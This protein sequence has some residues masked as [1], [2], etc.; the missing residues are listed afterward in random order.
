M[1]IAPALLADVNRVL[2]KRDARPRAALPEGRG[3][4]R[5][6]SQAGTT[7]TLVYDEIGYW[8]V[9]ARDVIAALADVSTPSITVRINSPGGDVFDGIA[10]YNALRGHPAAVNVVVD[11]L[12]ASAASFIAMAADRITMNAA[13]QLMI[14]D[15][16]GFAYGNAADMEHMRALL[17][18]VSD[19]IASIY[20]ERAGNDVADWRALM[21]DESWFNGAEAVAAGL[22]DE[23]ADPDEDDEDTDPEEETGG[24]PGPAARWDLSCFTFAGR[25]H[26][27]APPLPTDPEPEPVPEPAVDVAALREAL[28]GAFS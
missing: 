16:S 28:K 8:G 14:H 21:R 10:I 17:D 4:L 9:T 26:A 20:A 19:T 7:E 15:A 18:R 22:A 3:E 12:A 13:S 5:V 1:N 24:R 27:P 6:S 25:A 11:S 23:T 2:A